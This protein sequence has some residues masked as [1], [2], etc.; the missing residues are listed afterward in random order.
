MKNII[1][2]PPS[3]SLS[4]C[5]CAWILDVSLKRRV[6]GREKKREERM[7]INV[8]AFRNVHL[9]KS[10]EITN[11]SWPKELLKKIC[12]C[13]LVGSQAVLGSSN[14]QSEDCHKSLKTHRANRKQAE[15]VKSNPGIHRLRLPSSAVWGLAESRTATDW[16]GTSRIAPDWRAWRVKSGVRLQTLSWWDFI[17]GSILARSLPA[18]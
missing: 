5:F 3:P 18:C 11:L 2:L 15:K 1:L 10:L 12:V 7:E 9:M 16:T 6:R 14:F 13:N 8:Y 17:Q 4:L